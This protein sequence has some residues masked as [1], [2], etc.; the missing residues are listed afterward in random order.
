MSWDLGRTGLAGDTGFALEQ[1]SAKQ[2]RTLPD[3][4]QRSSFVFQSQYCERGAGG[5]LW[6]CWKL[7]AA[8]S[9]C[10]ILQPHSRAWQTSYHPTAPGDPTPQWDVLAGPLQNPSRSGLCEEAVLSISH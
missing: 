5:G 7:R 9:C 8:P 10:C 4:Y 2:T 3:V 6:P 1:F